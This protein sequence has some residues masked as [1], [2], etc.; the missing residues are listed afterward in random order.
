MMLRSKIVTRIKGR[1][2]ALK[3]AKAAALIPVFWLGSKKDKT[4]PATRTET[5]VN[6]WFESFFVR[7]VTY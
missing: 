6:E 4:P 7:V 5:Q 2:P 3:M 1:P